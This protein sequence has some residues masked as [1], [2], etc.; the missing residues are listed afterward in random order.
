VTETEAT[1]FEV[2]C[3]HCHKQFSAELI[4]GS[5]AR[6]RGFKCPHCRLFVPAAHGEDQPLTRDPDA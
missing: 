5:A 6:Y 2:E 3:P 1:G 4:E